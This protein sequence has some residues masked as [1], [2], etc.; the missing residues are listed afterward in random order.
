MGGKLVRLTKLRESESPVARAGKWDTFIPGEWDNTTSLPVDYTLTG[1]L[2]EAPEMGKRVRVLRLER[3]G[4]SLLGIF[5]SS[6]VTAVDA[7]WFATL[8]S[9]YRLEVLSPKMGPFS[10]ETIHTADSGNYE[11]DQSSSG[12]TS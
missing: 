10:R 1:F 12:A 4:E 11:I 2:L 3:N 9:V 5:E 7:S 8:N 6:I